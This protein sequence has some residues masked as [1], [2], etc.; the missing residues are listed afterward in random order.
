MFAIAVQTYPDSLYHGIHTWGHFSGPSAS[1]V[2]ECVLNFPMEHY[3]ALVR[4][5][6]NS[7]DLHLDLPT[8]RSNLLR[9]NPNLKPNPN[10]NSYMS[11]RYP[12]CSGVYYSSIYHGIRGSSRG[13][14][15]SQITKCILNSLQNTIR[16]ADVVR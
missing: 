1:Q 4:N 5:W 10:Q 2:G 15:A 11:T 3:S 9:I 12:Y 7:V 16:E 13:P 8:E 6:W 14:S